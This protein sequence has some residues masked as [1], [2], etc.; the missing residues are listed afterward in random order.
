M[1]R[2]LSY[3][4]IASAIIMIAPFTS[5]AQTTTAAS[6]DTV[7]ERPTM[8]L[9][10]RHRS[11]SEFPVVKGGLQ[12]SVFA[13][14]FGEIQSMALGQNGALYL[15]DSRS[16]RIT[17]IIDRNRDARPDI[18]RKLPFQF[19]RPR[20]LIAK[21][22][23][24]YV[25]DR[26]AV[27]VVAN[28]EQKQLASLTNIDIQREFLPM[29]LSPDEQSLYLAV[30]DKSDQS[31]I[32]Q[33]NLETGQ[34]AMVASGKGPVKAIAQAKGSPLWVAIS[35]RLVP[36]SDGEFAENLSQT[37]EQA[38]SIGALYLP[39]TDIQNTQGLG[40]LAGQF[41]VTQDQNQQSRRGEKATRN[42]VAIAST[43]GQPDGTPVP[44][45]EGFMANY[46]RAAWGRPGS[47]VW[48][49][50]GLFLVDKQNGLIWRISQIE[51]KITFSDRP[52]SDAI[53]LYEDDDI[54][55]PQAEWGSSISQGS[56]ILSGS[57]LTTDWEENKQIPKETLMEQLRREEEEKSKPEE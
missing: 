15:L 3:F 43:F 24:L 17:E 2:T 52:V 14:G 32:V 55:K 19:N 47:M 4:I 45:V 33:I 31:R 34:A 51:P 21:G 9:S 22:D 36:V 12:A 27:W 30:T 8:P 35:N 5:S 37:F 18:T 41:L 20:T 23:T 50:R 6:F 1:V 49:S 38:E 42:V 13:K 48:D 39:S 57:S 44:I 7:S 53:K 54:K 10:I 25:A 29:T 16:G 11:P 26:D 40:Y 46:G 56:S 28:R